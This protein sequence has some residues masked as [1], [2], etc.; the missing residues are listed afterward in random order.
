LAWA[1]RSPHRRLISSRC[2]ARHTPE[3]NRHSRAGSGGVG[4]GASRFWP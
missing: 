1:R 3:P 4:G 2:F